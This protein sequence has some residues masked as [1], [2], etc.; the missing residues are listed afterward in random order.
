MAAQASKAK[1]SFRPLLAVIPQY[2][3]VQQAATHI[4]ILPTV[5]KNKKHSY[6]QRHHKVV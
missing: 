1:A 3:E 5:Y 2:D 6:H 4:N